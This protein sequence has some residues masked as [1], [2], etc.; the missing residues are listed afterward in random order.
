MAAMRD[1]KIVETVG[2]CIYDLIRIGACRR[3]G[4]KLAAMAWTERRRDERLD[5]SANDLEN[6]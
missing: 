1:S 2:N 3:S 4:A 6:K 5:K